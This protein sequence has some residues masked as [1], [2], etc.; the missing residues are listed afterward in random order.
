MEFSGRIALRGDPNE[1][2]PNLREADRIDIEGGRSRRDGEGDLPSSWH[3]RRDVLQLEVSVRWDERV[4]V[5]A[6]EGLESELLQYKKMYAELGR[7]NYALKELIEKK[8]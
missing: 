4:G 3:Q 2:K 8:F 5:E 6:A 1:K 7:E